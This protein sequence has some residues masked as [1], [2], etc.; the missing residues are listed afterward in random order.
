M[1]N[2]LS[3]YRLTV[4]QYAQ[5][6]A[7][8]IL[9]KDDRVELIRGE[10]IDMRPIGSRHA[11][12]VKSFGRL[13]NAVV[14]DIAAV[15]VQDPVRLDAYSEPQPDI[16]VVHYRANLYADHHPTPADIL[17]LIE[18]ADSSVVYDR[19]TKISLYA[20]AGI[21]EVWLVDLIQNTITRYTV[22]QAGSYQRVEQ[23]T[24]GETICLVAEP[25][26]CITV[27]VLW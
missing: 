1:P 13:L 20:E 17:L 24:A 12:A 5:M 16:S 10:I 4:D 14:G 3:R 21:I 25:S 27:P 22:P 8:G 9:T 18:V 6:I 19:G 2:S 15:G 23:I 7:L 11:G 26:I